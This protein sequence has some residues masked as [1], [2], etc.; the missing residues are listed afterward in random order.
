MAIII[1]RGSSTTV[2]W[3]GI[4]QEDKEKL[5]AID[6]QYLP[7]IFPNNMVVWDSPRRR[8]VLHCLFFFELAWLP[9]AS[10]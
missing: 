9:P 8:V 6:H 10:E 7:G 4:Q 1:L 5:H 3:N 2:L